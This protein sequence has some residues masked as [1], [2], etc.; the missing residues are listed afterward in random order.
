M[1]TPALLELTQII[2]K[3]AELRAYEDLPLETR[4]AREMAL[5]RAIGRAFREADEWG[6]KDVPVAEDFEPD[7]PPDFEDGFAWGTREYD[8]LCSTLLSQA[9]EDEAHDDEFQ[10]AVKI[11]KII[12][13]SALMA[14]LGIDVGHIRMMAKEGG[15]DCCSITWVDGEVCCGSI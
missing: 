8:N 12:D 15:E 14:R 4:W 1:Q 6:R 11:E 7:A 13:E 2:S 9:G 10:L 3:D 5:D